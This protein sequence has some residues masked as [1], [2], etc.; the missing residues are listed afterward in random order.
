MT[1]LTLSYSEKTA[2][3]MPLWIASDA[4][5]FKEHGLDVT[6]RYLPPRRGSRR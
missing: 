1:P 3:M 5:Y 4:G 6:V 2:D